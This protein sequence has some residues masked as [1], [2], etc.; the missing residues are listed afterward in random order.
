MPDRVWCLLASAL[1]S[2]GCASAPDDETTG[3]APNGAAAEA[4]EESAAAAPSAASS[5]QAPAQ[6]APTL[7]VDMNRQ[8]PADSTGLIC[9]EMLKPLS[10]VIITKCMT[11]AAWKNYRKA[12]A[13]QAQEL[14]RFMR[15][16]R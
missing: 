8:P 9:R 6:I 7:T 11:P 2:A 4:A 14:L 16:G 13:L 1:L 12:E 10:N 3:S 15:S 5:V